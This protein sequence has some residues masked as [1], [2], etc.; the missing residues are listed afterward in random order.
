MISG[1]VPTIVMTFK[2][3]QAAQERAG[4]TPLNGWLGLVLYIVIVPAFWGYMQSGLN[5]AWRAAAEG[6]AEPQA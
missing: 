4:Q 3:V 2:R 6:D 5:S 1:R